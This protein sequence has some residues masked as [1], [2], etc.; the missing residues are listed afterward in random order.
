[1]TVHT[2]V[3][4]DSDLFDDLYSLWETEFEGKVPDVRS[5][6]DVRYLDRV[7]D[8]LKENAPDFAVVIV[9]QRAR[10]NKAEKGEP[11]LVSMMARLKDLQQGH[12]RSRFVLCLYEQ[13]LP[14]EQITTLVAAKIAIVWLSDAQIVRQE[15]RQQIH[16]AVDAARA[17]DPEGLVAPRLEVIA[18]FRFH[19]PD[20][21]LRLH[22]FY[23]GFPLPQRSI[24]IHGDA[25][26][27]HRFL[28]GSNEVDKIASQPSTNAT[29]AKLLDA[30]V[31]L[32]RVGLQIMADAALIRE[33]ETLENE[34]I[35]KLVRFRITT[36][37]ERYPCLFEALRI[38][39]RPRPVVVEH[40]TYRSVYF[41]QDPRLRLEWSHSNPVNVL[42]VVAN[43]PASQL[44]VESEKE[45]VCVN[46]KP[47]P[48]AEE[49]ANFF[50]RLKQAHDQGKPFERV[51]GEVGK[52]VKVA[53][54]RVDILRYDHKTP[55][56]LSQRL[57]K[58]LTESQYDILH[59]IGHAYGHPL[60]NDTIDTR[61]VLPTG[62]PAAA[63]ALTLFQL[64]N[65][66]NKS[67]VQ[68]VYLS[69]CSGIPTAGGAGVTLTSAAVAQLF[70]S[71]PLTLGF[72][73]DV[74]D[75]RAFEFA[76]DFYTELFVQGCDFDE[77]LQKARLNIYDSSAGS[78]PMWASPVLLLQ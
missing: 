69:C 26:L 77:A 48:F 9:N 57:R 71:I 34:H 56:L 54:G 68:F 27:M 1:M 32:D 52:P 33:Y 11:D 74:S 10:L 20:P 8:R 62:D 64:T 31:A 35:A 21:E 75:E 38:G 15:L 40:P 12:P 43:V 28:E 18:E 67:N 44:T 49:E 7:D 17:S 66:L 3:V 30:M 36:S 22:V 65:W 78:E 16:S 58:A 72:R 45:Q 24:P 70:Q 76:Q 42:V 46:F 63:E 50:T 37:T 2:I 73:W 59:F 13:N 29:R 6:E 4:G 23:G 19:I 25:I 41:G 51:D 61:L 39:A 14:F 53:V 5:P 47:L 55:V 60:P